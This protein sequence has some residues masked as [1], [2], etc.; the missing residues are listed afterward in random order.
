MFIDLRPSDANG[1]T[2][3]ETQPAGFIDGKD[4]LGTV[5]GVVAG[6]NSV[7]DVFTDVVLAT[8]GSLGEN[9]NF[10]ERPPAGGTVSAGQ[11]ATIG[12]WQNKNGQA[13]LRSLPAFDDTRM[14][15]P[16]V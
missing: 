16:R 10:G 9:Y 3:T 2:I 4:V 8:P 12:F 14:A 11:T 6:D 15:P 5:N 1:Y 7:N 13:L